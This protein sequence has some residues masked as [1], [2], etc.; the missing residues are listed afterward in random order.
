MRSNN[1]VGSGGCLHVAAV[2]ELQG[3]DARHAVV[4]TKGDYPAD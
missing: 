3:N 4:C 2:A 1:R